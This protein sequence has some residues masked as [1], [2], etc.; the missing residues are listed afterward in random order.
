MD[1][2]N[3]YLNLLYLV[4][5]IVL[6]L[7]SLFFGIKKIVVTLRAKK[8]RGEEITANDLKLATLEIREVAREA[9]YEAE[10]Q[11]NNMK[12]HGIRAGAFKL[13]SVLKTVDNECLRRG[14]AF[15][16]EEITEYVNEEVSKMKGVH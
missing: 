1:K 6:A 10:R 3:T 5:A 11:Y 12:N 14:I 4:I 9:I 7:I 15:N 13:D 8:A 2:F 16:K